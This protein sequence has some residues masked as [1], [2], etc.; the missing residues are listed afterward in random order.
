V[1]YDSIFVRSIYDVKNMRVTDDKIAPTLNEAFVLQNTS[2]YV[3]FLKQELFC[4]K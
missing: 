3:I 1:Y 2:G 4:Y